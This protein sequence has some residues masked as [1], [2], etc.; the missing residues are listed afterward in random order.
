MN[1]AVPPVAAAKKPSWTPARLPTAV[2][3]VRL[4]PTF[5]EI[6]ALL[7]VAGGTTWATTRPLL[8]GDAFADGVADVDSLG[9][10][11][12]DSESSGASDGSADSVGSAFSVGSAD[13]FSLADSSSPGVFS[14]AGVGSG[15]DVLSASGACLASFVAVSSCA[16]TVSVGVG[17]GVGADQAA[18]GAPLNSSTPIT[19]AMSARRKPDKR[20]AGESR[21]G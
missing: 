15:V 9:S 11:L 17:L 1:S 21:T 2:W 10:S 6:T 12:G 4:P 5:T 20:R 8:L 18:R 7:P 19:R 13:G 3:V 16:F 14:G